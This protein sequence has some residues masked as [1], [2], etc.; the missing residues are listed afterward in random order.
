MYK[1]D[2]L[3]ERNINRG[4]SASAWNDLLKK[5]VIFPGEQLE[6]IQTSFSAENMLGDIK[7][8]LNESPE[9]PVEKVIRKVVNSVLE[10]IPSEYYAD[11]DHVRSIQN[12][13]LEILRKRGEKAFVN[14]IENGKY[15]DYF[16]EQIK[17]EFTKKLAEEDTNKY[18]RDDKR[19]NWA[20]RQGH[21][22][23]SKTENVIVKNSY[24][25]L[26]LIPE[27]IQ[28]RHKNKNLTHG[29][30][31]VKSRKIDEAYRKAREDKE[32]LRYF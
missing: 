23:D 4:Y 24:G 8:Q 22:K 16:D 5:G 19:G 6:K 20:S 13:L 1:G 30:R 2:P 21:E 3:G 7:Q 18:H 11:K 10:E 26:V 28:E 25:D 17:L 15:D 32:E 31:D 9:M 12:S 14:I 27:K 29:G